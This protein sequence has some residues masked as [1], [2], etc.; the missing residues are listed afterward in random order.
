MATKE[1]RTWE[2]V[3]PFTTPYPML[4]GFDSDGEWHAYAQQPLYMITGEEMTWEILYYMVMQ[5]DYELD[6][7]MSGAC[8]GNDTEG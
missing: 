3:Q 4:L 6:Y 7:F 8:V 1:N 2:V 5:M